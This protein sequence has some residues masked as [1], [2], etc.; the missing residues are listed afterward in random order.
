M[1]HVS[2]AHIRSTLFQFGD[3]D[4]DLLSLIAIGPPAAAVRIVNDGAFFTAPRSVNATR[5]DIVPAR[6]V[7]KR[8]GM[9]FG[10]D[11]VNR[12]AYGREAGMQQIVEVV[13]GIAIDDGV[14]IDV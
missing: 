5:T 2:I 4:I 9:I 12:Q 6:A 3:G 8:S 13:Y 10:A 1:N 11:S 14:L 7:S